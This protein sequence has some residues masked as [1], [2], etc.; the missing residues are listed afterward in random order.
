FQTLARLQCT[1][2]RLAALTLTVARSVGVPL[3]IV[4][5]QAWECEDEIDLAHYHR[6]KT[7]ALFAAAT[8]AGAASAG[9]D[10]EPWRMVG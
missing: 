5:G 8:V 2:E 1:P 10:C 3:G 9:A 7:G 4:A 6:A